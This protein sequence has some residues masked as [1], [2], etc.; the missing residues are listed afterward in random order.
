MSF[1]KFSLRKNSARP[2]KQSY[3]IWQQMLIIYVSHSWIHFPDARYIIKRVLRTYLSAFCRSSVE[4]RGWSSSSYYKDAS[5]KISGDRLL[6]KL[7][8]VLAAESYLIYRVGCQRA[9]A[10]CRQLRHFLKMMTVCFRICGSV[11]LSK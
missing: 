1:S 7:T 9:A 5:V 10:I 11:H 6:T 8:G 2:Y 3:S 4:P